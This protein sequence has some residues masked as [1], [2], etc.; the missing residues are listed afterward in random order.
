MPDQA[1]VPGLHVLAGGAVNV[2]VLDDPASGVCVVDAGLPGAAKNILELVRQIGRAPQDVKHILVTHAD[3]DHVGGLKPLAAQTGAAIYASA[4]SDTYLQQAKNPPHV[5]FPASLFGGIVKRFFAGAVK[6][7]HI[8]AEGQTLDIAG[9]IRV[10]LTPGHTP[11][12]V[13]YYWERERV[14]FPGDLFNTREGL[15]LTP[16][17]ITYDMA[18]AHQHARRLLALDPLVIC[19]GHGQP[20]IAREHPEQLEALQAQLNSGSAHT[21]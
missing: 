19:P 16:A 13:S 1:I 4:G 2:Y 14:L 9:G 11:D 20:W 18:L 21:Q 8:V 12:S 5:G 10:L 17:R 15:A 7:D 6:A 3:V